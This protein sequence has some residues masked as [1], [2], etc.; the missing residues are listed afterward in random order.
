MVTEQN[1]E[2]LERLREAGFSVP[3]LEPGYKAPT[4]H[5][6]TGKSVTFKTLDP[7]FADQLAEQGYYQ[8][9]RCGRVMNIDHYTK[10]KRSCRECNGLASSASNARVRGLAWEPPE[11]C[12]QVLRDAHP[13][14]EANPA[15][16]AE[17]AAKEEA[18]RAGE[19]AQG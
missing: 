3:E 15:K 1:R 19:A 5:R 11:D 7:D 10:N 2:M 8:C 12:D 18:K 14:F 13:A 4:A 16:A 9:S 17:W 6:A